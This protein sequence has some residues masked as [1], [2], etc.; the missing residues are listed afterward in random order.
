MQVSITYGLKYNLICKF[1]VVYRL[2]P[3][4]ATNQKHGFCAAKQKQRLNHEEADRE[5]WRCSAK[6]LV[7]DPAT[8]L[9]NRVQF[10]SDDRRPNLQAVAGSFGPDVDYTHAPEDLPRDGRRPGALLASRVYWGP[11]ERDRG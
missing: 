3:F 4:A 1:S 6:V 7:N 10:T 9:A 8:R 11:D 5:R 2:P